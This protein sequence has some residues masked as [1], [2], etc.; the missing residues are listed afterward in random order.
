MGSSRFPG[1]SLREIMGKPLLHYVVEKAKQVAGLV[2]VLTSDRSVDDPIEEFCVSNDILF[3]R[4][5][6]HD[7]FSRFRE[8]ALR[9][10]PESFVRLTGDN[11]FVIPELVQEGLRKHEATSADMTT[12]RFLRGGVWEKFAPKGLSFDIIRTG[13]FLAIDP[14]RISEGTKEHVIIHYY[15]NASRYV[16]STVSFEGTTSCS[17]DTF[18]EFER[19]KVIIERFGANS[20][21]SE[22]APG[23]Q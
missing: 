1:K 21:Y 11:P 12:T 9:F 22:I 16:I 20:P 8:A 5:S 6:E 10:R 18:E 15:E 4:G 23:F 3:L 13:S 7:V 17:I 2:V 14:D 19:A